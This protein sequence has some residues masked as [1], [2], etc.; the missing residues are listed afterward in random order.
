MSLKF[1]KI[2]NGDGY[3]ILNKDLDLPPELYFKI[4]NDRLLWVNS[5]VLCFSFHL[6]LPEVDDIKSVNKQVKHF[7]KGAVGKNIT[8]VEEVRTDKD[9][10]L[11]YVEINAVKKDRPTREFVEYIINNVVDMVRNG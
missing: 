2:R 10:Y 11:Y 7:I 3:H 8:V 4:P 1:K 6:R 5:A 9:N